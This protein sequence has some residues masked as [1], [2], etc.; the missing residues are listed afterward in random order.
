MRMIASKV[1]RRVA[2]SYKV[3]AALRWLGL[4]SQPPG[5]PHVAEPALY[6]EWE[7]VVPPRYLWVG[8][9]DSLAHFV[10]WPLEYRAY[11]TLLCGLRTDSAVLELGCNHG[12]TALGLLDYLRT[13][14][15]YEGLDI[16]PDHV[17]FARQEIQQRFPNFSFTVAD[18]HNRTYNPAGRL[19]AEN[20]RF[21]YPD[22]SFDVIYAASLF[23]HLLPPATL[24][25]LCE[26]RRVLRAGGACLFSFFVLDDYPQRGPRATA[27]YRF[28]HSLETFP[29]VATVNPQRPEDIVAYATVRIREMAKVAGFRVE[30]V[31]PGYWSDAHP[32]SVNEQDLVLLTPA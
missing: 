2:D 5:V 1:A 12:R 13:P 32:S 10:R 21:P 25:Y 30:R 20:Y 26:S 7:A 16:L 11:L 27:A 14:G 19:P 6:R 31:L 8:P 28:D 23:T 15:R 18:I 29:G 4:R 24:N 17:A 22:G 9:G 3:Q